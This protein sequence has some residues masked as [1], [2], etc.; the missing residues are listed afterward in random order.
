MVRAAFHGLGRADRSADASQ[1]TANRIR[2]LALG[3]SRSRCRA[4]GA[5]QARGVPNGGTALCSVRLYTSELAESVK[6]TND[7]RPVAISSVEARS[8]ERRVGKEC[9]YRGS[10][11]EDRKK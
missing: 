7:E 3:T 10:R 11:Y 1:W 9:R 8:E 6:A 2:L 4:G 5:V